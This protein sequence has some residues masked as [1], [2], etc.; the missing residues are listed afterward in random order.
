MPSGPAS[1]PWE[2]ASTTSRRS[3]DSSRTVIVERA[4]R[5]NVKRG[6]GV[7]VGAAIALDRT[8]TDHRTSSSDGGER[9]KVTR[10]S[11]PR[12]GRREYP[13]VTDPAPDSVRAAWAAG[14]AAR[15]GWLT[16]A[17]PHLVEVVAA[18]A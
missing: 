9:G 1:Q 10:V 5:E 13:P 4:S 7:R 14:R 17:D 16:V 8:G 11:A 18:H 12:P 15:N 3:P 2:A 6:A